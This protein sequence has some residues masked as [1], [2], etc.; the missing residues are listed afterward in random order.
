[1]RWPFRRETRAAS[2][3]YAADIAEGA[4]AKAAGMRAEADALAATATAVN[5]WERCLMMATVTPDGPALAPLDAA[6]RGLVGRA[7]GTHGEF[8]ALIEVD[9]AT[10]RLLPASGWDV[11]GGSPE[12]STWYYWLTLPG[13]Q[14]SRTVV[15]PASEVV[16]VRIGASVAQPW[17]GRSPLRTARTTGNLAG[18][19]EAALSRESMMPIGRIVALQHHRSH[20]NWKDTV[21]NVQAGGVTVM[22][23]EGG[24]REQLP[25][26]RWAPAKYGP[27]PDANLADA[28]R[29]QLGR[30]ILSA[31]G[32]PPTLYAEAGDGSGQR[33]AWRRLWLGTIAPLAETL[34]AE[35]RTKLDDR[36]AV[37][38][39]AL[40]AADEDARSRAVSRRVQAAAMALEKLEMGK[41]EALRLAGL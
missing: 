17:R 14:G 21:K 29:S 3:D 34:A 37:D 2:G 1:M 16:H 32:V 10:V 27:E 13:P 40:R 26:S 4:M 8:L 36:A 7:L 38:L 39:E 24:G 11:Y 28:L 33:E 22:S 31:Y 19:V 12:P 5:L 30:E 25:G 9:G 6:M 35:A 41:A 15:R 18:R 20:E 23:Q